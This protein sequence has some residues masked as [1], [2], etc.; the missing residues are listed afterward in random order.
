MS[1]RDSVIITRF[2]Q[3]PDRTDTTDPNNWF[4]LVCL[5]PLIYLENVTRDI[6]EGKRLGSLGSVFRM[7][8][9]EVAL[10]DESINF[11]HE[12]CLQMGRGGRTFINPFGLSVR[13][14]KPAH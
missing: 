9:R 14:G 2:A 13:K 7:R 10:S 8:E 3:R 4:I 5:C 6:R 12:C 11:R 1:R